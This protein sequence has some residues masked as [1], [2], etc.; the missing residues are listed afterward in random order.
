M[1][2]GGGKPA[3]LRKLQAISVLKRTNINLSRLL[4][5]YNSHDFHIAVF[6]DDTVKLG[7]LLVLQGAEGSTETI[8]RVF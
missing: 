5:N 1:G 4:G 7:R 2:K 3:I 6:C 8:Y